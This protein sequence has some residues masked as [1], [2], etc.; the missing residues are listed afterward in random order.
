MTTATKVLSARRRAGLTAKELAALA[1]VSGA[2][3]SRAEA[4]KVVPS[5]DAYMRILAA[6]GFVD[7]GDRLEPLS[8]PSAV[9]TARWLTGDLDTKPQ[10]ADQWTAAWSRI[11]LVTDA[12]EIVDVES[13]LF[14]AGRSAVLSARPGIVNLACA[15]PTPAVVSRL[16][17][18]G[19]EY[20]VTGDEALTR[21]GSSIIPSWPVVYVADLPGAV[22]AIGA[23]PVLP[24]ERT[25][26]VSLLPFDQISEAGRVSTGDGCFVTPLQAV[27]DGYGG[28]GR[29]VEQA[30]LVVDVWIAEQA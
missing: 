29:M 14:R 4:G 23:R 1:G 17:A 11:G 28:Y 6:A 20:A 27:L 18:A 30:E 26:R 2:T 9:W 15:L 24:R 3:I 13:L 19:I 25:P 8:R 22:D 16:E 10:G 21:L 5:A 12:L 7:L